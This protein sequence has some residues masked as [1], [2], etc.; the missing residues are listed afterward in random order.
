M[1]ERTYPT[2]IHDMNEMIIK[3]VLD[4]TDRQHRIFIVST[5]MWMGVALFN[6]YLF[7]TNII[8]LPEFSIAL[9]ILIMALFM[10]RR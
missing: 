4:G 5:I 3:T 2:R 9:G 10:M 1:N 7:Y 8:E 6:S